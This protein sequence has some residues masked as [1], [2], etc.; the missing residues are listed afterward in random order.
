M[1]NNIN[2]Y[3]N[4]DSRFKNNQK[5]QNPCNF[6]VSLTVPV[7]TGPSVNG[8][9]LNDSFFELGSIDPDYSNTDLVFY[10]G[11]V[12]NHKIDSDGTRYYL[13]YADNEEDDLEIFEIE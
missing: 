10:N 9:P 5:Y 3:V 6:G 11:T 13:D 8:L 4:I 7:S 1:S 2:Y 12:L